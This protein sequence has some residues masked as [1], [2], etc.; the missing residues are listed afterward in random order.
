MQIKVYPKEVIISIKKRKIL[1]VFEILNVIAMVTSKSMNRGLLY[2][3]V[4]RYILEEV[5]KYAVFG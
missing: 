5:I 1:I 2:Q 3:I 4:S